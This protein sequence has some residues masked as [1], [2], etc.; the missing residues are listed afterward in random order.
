MALDIL[1]RM[2]DLKCLEILLLYVIVLPASLWKLNK[3][4]LLSCES[5]YHKV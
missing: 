2:D 5:A 1:F 3:L 4:H